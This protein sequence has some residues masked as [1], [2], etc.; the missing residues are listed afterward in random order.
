[1][2][3]A[4]QVC[5]WLSEDYLIGGDAVS[6]LLEVAAAV[7]SGHYTN[8]KPL[9]S[10]SP[11]IS[12][13]TGMIQDGKLGGCHGPRY[14]GADR[15]Y[16]RRGS[17]VCPVSERRCAGATAVN[18]CGPTR[19]GLA[20]RGGEDW[21]HGSSDVAGLGDPVQRAGSGRSHQYSFSGGAAQAQ[22]HTQSLSRLNRRRRAR[23]LRSMAWCAGGRA[24]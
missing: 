24:I 7:A 13:S 3:P 15:L 10:L 14:S 8:Y 17:P 11:G 16:C 2:V 1:L 22:R 12:E 6:G 5:S 20:G 9:D 18:N 4:C 19:W 23:S 21:W